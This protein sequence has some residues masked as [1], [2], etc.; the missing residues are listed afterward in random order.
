MASVVIQPATVGANLSLER[1]QLMHG[2]VE[3]GLFKRMYSIALIHENERVAAMDIGF[4]TII[5]VLPF[6]FTTMLAPPQGH[7]RASFGQIIMTFSTTV[8]AG[9]T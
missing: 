7:F 8:P 2:S 4:D 6:L 5:A 3:V 1:F 9:C